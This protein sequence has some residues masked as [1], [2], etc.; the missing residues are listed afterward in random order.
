ME[1]AEGH[2]E[3]QICLLKEKEGYIAQNVATRT[4][5]T[6]NAVF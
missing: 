1:S 3:E 5:N 2:K 6:K 4:Y